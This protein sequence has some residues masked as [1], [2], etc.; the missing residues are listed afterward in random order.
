M[1]NRPLELVE[2][3]E[4]RALAAQ[5]ME[6]LWKDYT[7]KSVKHAGTTDT[8]IKKKINAI[9]SQYEQRVHRAIKYS[10]LIGDAKQKIIEGI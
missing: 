5:E 6:A 10:F 7:E 9:H 8:K 2:L 3:Q 4:K 1:R